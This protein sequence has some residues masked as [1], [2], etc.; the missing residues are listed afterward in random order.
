M[1]LLFVFAI[2]Y[3]LLKNSVK[4]IPLNE[5]YPFG[6]GTA[7]EFGTDTFLPPNDDGSSDQ[8][9]LTSV[10]PFFDENF[11]TIFVCMAYKIAIHV[12]ACYSQLLIN[13]RS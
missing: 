9:L 12:Y 6:S 7:A 13:I 10:F 5:F 1:Q 3:I 11:D 2:F 8:I 4:C